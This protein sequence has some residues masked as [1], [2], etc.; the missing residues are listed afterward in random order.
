[1]IRLAA[2]LSHPIQYFSPLFRQVAEHPGV[3]L[4]VFYACRHGLTEYHDQRF[5]TTFAWD[6]PLL[7]GYD[8][9]FL[10]IER[11]PQRLTFMEVDNPGA[12]TAVGRF[13]PDVLMLFGYGHRTNWRLANWARRP[14]VPVLL[15][16]DS[17]SRATRGIARLVVKETLVR[18]FYARIDGALYVSD[19]NYW[20]HRHFGLPA[21]RLFPGILPVDTRRFALGE[22]EKRRI[23]RELRSKLSIPREDFVVI[24]AAK[25]IAGKRQRDLVEAS[26]I[27][28]RRLGRRV[29]ALLVGEGADRRVLEE[30]VLALEA[31]AVVT[32]F[33]NQSAMPGYYATADAAILCSEEEPHGL[34]LSEAV[35]AGLPVIVSDRIGSLGSMGATQP[36]RNALVYPCGD[37]AALADALQS[38]ASDEQL[39]QELRAQS[40]DLADELDIG[41]AAA[42][43]AAAATHLARRHE[44]EAASWR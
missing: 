7:E 29:W 21:D 2:V 34:A 26:A 15:M 16:S 41:R 9:E 39:R 19:R 22:A 30:R 24:L 13:G 40:I 31:P 32:G 3:S 4:K 43:V 23:R 37:V 36:G 20:Y 11:E 14:P 38:L 12:G 10:P 8:S 44:C 33:V 28:S 35:A 25:M 27:V 42:C 5:G 1:M 18:A 6:I 17:S